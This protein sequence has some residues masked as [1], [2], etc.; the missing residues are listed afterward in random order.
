MDDDTQEFILQLNQLVNTSSLLAK[1][2]KLSITR[3]NF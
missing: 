3:F 1:L 2:T